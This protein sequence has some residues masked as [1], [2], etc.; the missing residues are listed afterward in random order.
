MVVHLDSRNAN[1]RLQ[2]AAAGT[3][4]AAAGTA[5]AA[6]GTAAAAAG[7]AAAA[8][9][10]AAAAAGTLSRLLHRE[11]P[12]RGSVPGN[13]KRTNQWR[14]SRNRLFVEISFRSSFFDGFWKLAT[15][16]QLPLCLRLL[17]DGLPIPRARTKSRDWGAMRPQRHWASFYLLSLCFAVTDSQGLQQLGVNPSGNRQSLR[18]LEPANRLAAA[19]AN[20]PVNSAMVIA[21]PGKFR[22]H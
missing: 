16:M 4:A 15:E 11:G 8:A 7:T 1:L 6:A 17:A 10:T 13:V 9:G 19:R 20:H 14:Q 2:H 5:A 18:R 12:V 22:L 21:S 3:A